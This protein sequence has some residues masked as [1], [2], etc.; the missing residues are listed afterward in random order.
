MSELVSNPLSLPEPES[1]E[2]QAVAEITGL[3]GTEYRKVIRLGAIAVPSDRRAERDD[4]ADSDES[5]ADS[6]PDFDPGAAH[7]R[8]R[9]LP[10]TLAEGVIAAARASLR[11]AVRYPRSALAAGLSVVILGT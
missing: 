4:E 6:P 8:A 5:D 7:Q 2:S 9:G 11:G 3:A 10:E 1:T